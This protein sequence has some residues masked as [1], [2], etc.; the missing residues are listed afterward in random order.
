M[1]TLGKNIFI[2]W[3]DG[4]QMQLVAG[5]RA[6]EISSHANKIE[7][8]SATQQ[9]WEDFIAG[10]KSWNFSVAFL[11]LTE[12]QMQD[13]LKTGNIFS[14]QVKGATAGVLL[15]G[16]AM[17]T[18]AKYSMADGTLANGSFSFTGKGP[19]SLPPASVSQL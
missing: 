6:N 15:T 16:S 18:D 11:L 1:A 19:L 2:Y 12:S 7:I 10:R 9:D 4:S 14:I 13:L 8:A 17:L 5:T 3:N